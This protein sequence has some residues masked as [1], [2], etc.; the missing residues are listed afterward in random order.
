MLACRAFKGVWRSRSGIG[1]YGRYGIEKRARTNPSAKSSQSRRDSRKLKRMIDP[2]S[3]EAAA[4]AGE[5]SAQWLPVV[6]PPR[7]EA[8][9]E[10]LGWQEP[11][12]CPQPLPDGLDFGMLG[13]ALGVVMRLAISE[14][15]FWTK[16]TPEQRRHAQCMQSLALVFVVAPGA[17]EGQSLEAVARSVGGT[18]QDLSRRILRIRQ[19]L[20]PRQPDPMAAFLAGNTPK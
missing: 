19:C 7:P 15:L 13:D 9:D 3:V 16:A 11:G 14:V 5:N 17:F 12:E 2:Q 6:H 20:L 1:R 4:W 10:S 18:K 8:H